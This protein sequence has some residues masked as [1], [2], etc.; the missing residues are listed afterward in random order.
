MLHLAQFRQSQDSFRSV[1][2]TFWIL[3]VSALFATVASAQTPTPTPITKPDPPT[4][5]TPSTV[6]RITIWSGASKNGIGILGDSVITQSNGNIGIDVTTPTDKLS[7]GGSISATGPINTGTHFSISGNRV[8]FLDLP[9]SNLF[10]GFQAGFAN[11]TG[12]ANTF[13]GNSS[14]VVNSTG[15]S[16]SFFGYLAGRSN[17]SGGANSFFGLQA[18]FSNTIGNGN[19][20]FGLN[21]GNSNTLGSSNSFFGISSGYKNSTGNGNAFFGIVTGFNNTTGGNNSFFGGNA[22]Q[23]NTTESNNTFIG[24]NSNGVAGITNATALGVNALVTQSNSVV[25]GNNA[26]VGIGTSAPQAKLHVIGSTAGQFDG[27]V[28]FNGN[29]AVSGNANLTATNAIHAT[30]ATTA[31]SANSLANTATVNGNQVNG[32]LTNATIAGTA[33]TGDIAATQVSGNL[34]NATMSGNNITSGTVVKGLNGLTDNVTL[35]AG[36]NVTIT[37]SGNT[38]TISSADSSRRAVLGQWWT[39]TPHVDTNLGITNLA[40]NNLQTVISDGADVWVPDFIDSVWRVRASDGKVMEQWTGVPRGNFILSAMGRIFVD[41]VST[42]SL[43]MIDPSQPAGPVTTV[44]SLPTNPAG[45]AFDG[46]RIWIANKLDA[47]VSIIT[48]G[49]TLPWT[50]QT[51]PGFGS[52]LGMLYDGNNIWV[53]DLGDNKLKKLDSSGNVIQAISVGNGP[54]KP[55][56]DGINIWVPNFGSNTITVVN[57]ATGNVVNTLSGNG[58]NGPFGMAFDGK[59]VLVANFNGDSV[60]LWKL[61]DL[62]PLGSYST[63]VGSRP[64]DVACD[65]LNFWVSLN[66]SGKLLRF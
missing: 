20:F 44:A 5:Q 45:I 1:I 46:S 10:A 23:S 59:R 64:L 26:N 17:T 9:R 16:N 11:N 22:G 52:P 33:I 24:A 21:A 65:G 60:S 6:G 35:A 7:V 48:P 13:F 34:T 56:F 49:A 18:G 50:V 61:T 14:G 58:L 28:T 53:T 47:S 4:V 57:A 38:L 62:V 32:A 40:G 39:T 8:L 30:T 29:I 51:I 41:D 36:N 19:S 63:G 15:S 37:P 25:L 54:R 2:S 3:F 31:D 55:F 27:S 43:C 42:N 66:G 12:A